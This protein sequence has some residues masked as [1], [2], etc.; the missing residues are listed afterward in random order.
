VEENNKRYRKHNYI[1]LRRRLTNIIFGNDKAGNGATITIW[2]GLK[3]VIYSL[4]MLV[5]IKRAINILMV[6]ISIA[7]IKN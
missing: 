4:I 3:K 1:E 7:K 6:P 5:Y 2:T